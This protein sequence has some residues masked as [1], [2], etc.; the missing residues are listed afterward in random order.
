MT[1]KSEKLYQQAKRR[2]PGGVNSPVRAFKSIG[3][4]P[5]FIKAGKGSHIWDEDEN[6]YID[7]V[8]SWGALILGHAY[9]DIVIALQ[10]QAGLGTSYGACTRLEVEMAEKI[11]KA[12]PSMEVLRMVNSGTEATMSAIRCAR[13]YTGRDLIVKCSGCYHGHSDSLLIQAGSGVLTYG[14]P[15]SEGVTKKTAQDT[16]LIPYN[17]TEIVEK[18]FKKYGEQIAAVIVEPVVGNMGT[19]L[20][21]LEFLKKLRENTSA[22]GSLLI[23]DEVIT[24]FRISYSGAQGWFKIVPDL[25]T[26]GKVIGGGLSV[27]AYGG[28]EEIMRRVAPDGSVYQAGTLAGNPFTLAAGLTTLNILSKKL[29]LYSELERKAKLL[30]QGFYD[31]GKQVGVPITIN[32]LGSMMTLFFNQKPVDNLSSA[33]QSNTDQYAFFCRGMLKE[34]IYFPPSQFESFFLSTTHTDQ[35]IEKT[36]EAA[37]RVLKFIHD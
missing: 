33:L 13:G 11:Y 23:F 16:I 20:P 18:V 5:P 26:L 28:K 27:G 25:T 21:R 14:I 32:R 15:G 24:G 35:D 37:Y 22:Y 34:G 7:Y 3:I 29:I 8:M 31:V 10:K 6:E 12:I 1:L 2:M 19:V 30:C 9:P 17:N 4:S 36:I